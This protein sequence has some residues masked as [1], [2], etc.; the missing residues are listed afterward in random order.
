MAALRQVDVDTRALEIAPFYDPF[1]PKEKYNVDY[2]DYTTTEQLKLKASKIPNFC[3]SDIPAVDFVWS[4]GKALRECIP[5][6]RE[7]D[8]VVASH[9]LE[10]VPNPLGWLNEI[11][12]IS[13]H[14]GYVALFLPDRRM[15]ND[16]FRRETDFGQLVQWWIEQPV[17]PTPGQILDSLAHAFVT[18][19]TNALR[20]ESRDNPVYPLDRYYCDEEAM[21]FATSAHSENEYVDVH[22][23]VWTRA[24]AV[25]LFE[26]AVEA[27][28]LNVEIAGVEEDEAEFLILL[29]KAGEPKRRP[30][31]KRRSAPDLVDH[32]FK[33]SVEHQLGVLRHDLSFLVKLVS[34][35]DQKQDRQEK[36]RRR[37]SG[38]ALARSK[39]KPRAD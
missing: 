9:V 36:D 30:P 37:R 16:F 5:E 27:G 15:P 4:P 31:P 8:F 39:R 6:R 10:H 19:G 33:M 25:T 12:S 34:D 14:G 29:R 17:V 32:A 26:R 13:R 3:E 11:L 2:T 35:I 1:L 18:P 20:F 22:C 23:T 28:I 24:S 21:A 7:Y 38:L